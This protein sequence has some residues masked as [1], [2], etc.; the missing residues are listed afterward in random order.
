MNIK[1]KEANFSTLVDPTDL[2]IF[3]M[4]CITNSF[5]FWLMCL[6][7]FDLHSWFESFSFEFWHDIMI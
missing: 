4:S 5:D 2:G 3:P 1:K 7:T 6:V